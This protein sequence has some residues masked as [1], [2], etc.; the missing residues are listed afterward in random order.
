[1]VDIVQVPFSDARVYVEVTPPVPFRGGILGVANIIPAAE[2]GLMGAEYLTDACAEGSLWTDICYN[3]DQQLCDPASTPDPPAD[4]YKVFDKPDLVQGD[5]FATHAG[6]DCDLASMADNEERA[7]RSLEYAEGREIDQHFWL[8]MES[9]KS[10]DIGL[11]DIVTTIMTLDDLSS[12]LYGGYGVIH[13]TRGMT[14]CARA[15]KAI[16]PAPD[17][18]WITVNGT[19]I[20][21]LANPG[22]AGGDSPAFL[23]GQ[24][25]LIQGDVF[26]FAVPPVTRPDGSC[27]PQR[28]LAERMYVPLIECMVVGGTAT[29]DTTTPPAT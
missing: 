13:L 24:I 3:V 14:V 1:M 19:R 17:G 9:L 16:Q 2:H 29:C 26:S 20:A 10:T 18:G 27:D 25:T 8:L 4:G 12:Q 21:N 28:A 6:V 15:E 23:T 11:N 22:V 5:P 7:R